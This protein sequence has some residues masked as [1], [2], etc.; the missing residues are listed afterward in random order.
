MVQ[1]NIMYA[2]QI[3]VELNSKIKSLANYIHTILLIIA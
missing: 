2:P 1:F 3:P